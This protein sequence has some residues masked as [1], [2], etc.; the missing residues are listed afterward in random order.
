MASAVGYTAPDILKRLL[1]APTA[2]AP[3]GALWVRNY[4]E[5]L[6]LRGGAWSL[7]S[8]AGLAA[9]YLNYA[10]SSVGSG[11]GFRPALVI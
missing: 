7:G 4:G 8:N 1:I 5:R 2:I 9:L 6:P 3:Q 11:I 10:R